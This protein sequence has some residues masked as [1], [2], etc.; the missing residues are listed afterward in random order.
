MER[1][2]PRTNAFSKR[3]E[4]HRRALAVFLAYY[5]FVRPHVCIRK[6]PALAA[7]L[8]TEPYDLEWLARFAE[9]NSDTTR[10]L[11]SRATPVQPECMIPRPRPR[12]PCIAS[13]GTPILSSLFG[14]PSFAINETWG[15]CSRA[16]ERK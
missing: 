3:F 10:R 1:F 14:F 6:T 2:T 11:G 5:N 12:N 13:F 4:N 15:S 16:R 8:T 9:S 7:S